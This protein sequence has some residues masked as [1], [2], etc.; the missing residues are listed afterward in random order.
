MEIIELLAAYMTISGNQLMYCIRMHIKI[1]LET[2]PSPKSTSYQDVRHIHAQVTF[3][4]SGAP[5]THVS[6]IR[7]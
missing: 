4:Y 1:N 3:F 7:R 6:S 5:P 2:L